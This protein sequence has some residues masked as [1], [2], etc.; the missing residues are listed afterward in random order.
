VRAALV[1][2]GWTVSTG[3]R[4]PLV[5]GVAALGC[6]L[7][8]AGVALE[9]LALGT[10]S[11]ALVLG[12]GTAEAVALLVA[13]TTPPRTLGDDDGSGLAESIDGGG[14]GYASRL[15]GRFLGAWLLSLLA[16]APALALSVALYNDIG[17]G[18][19]P[20]SGWLAAL[21]VEVGAVAAWCA[22]L[23]RVLPPAPA[24]LVGLLVLV[25]ARVGVP[26]PLGALLP[27]PLDAVV[28]TATTVLVSQA[29][30]CVA[31]IAGACALRRT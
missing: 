15:T 22:L 16:A 12:V 18:P 17:A 31:A 29:L 6:L 13:L 3:L 23:A 19:A 28:P 4:R 8:W 21:A 14:G 11:R 30:V 26:E 7:L 9:I 27:R 1:I 10:G 20:A 25:S 2:A 24:T 5:Y